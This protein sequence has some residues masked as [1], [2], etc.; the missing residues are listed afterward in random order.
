MRR[1]ANRVVDVYQDCIVFLL[2][3][4]YQKA[5]ANIKKRL[6]AYGLTPVQTLVLEAVVS[7]EG[8]SAGDLAGKLVLDSAT[9]SGVL[10]RMAEKDWISKK[11]DPDDKRVLRIYLTE[12]AKSLSEDLFREREE[13][14][15]E[16]LR[17]LSLEERLLLKRLL[18]DIR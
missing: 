6:N 3:K 11:T 9:L 1:S 18:R 12:K 8:L 15:R 10:D 17:D 14:N 5:H 13:A 16:I 4:A 2:A 7:E